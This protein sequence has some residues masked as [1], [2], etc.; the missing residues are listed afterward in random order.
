VSDQ[1]VGRIER[2]THT[3]GPWRVEQTSANNWIGPGRP[4]GKV[5]NVVCSIDRNG[6]KPEALARNDANARLIAAAPELLAAAHAAWHALKSYQYGNAAPDL[7][8]DCAAVLE[9][10]IA[11]AEGR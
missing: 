5:E 2:L 6:L 9:D 10:A 7:A 3:P 8:A 4:S 1:T 11:K